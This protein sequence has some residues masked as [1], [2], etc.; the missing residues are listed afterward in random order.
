MPVAPI[1]WYFIWSDRYEIFANILKQGINMYPTI[2]QDKNQY[3]S[4]EDF[5]KHLNKA[6]GH[7]LCGCFLKLNK[8][9]E[10]LTTLPENS[11]FIF[12]DADILIFPNRA[13]EDLINLYIKINADIVFM[14]EALNSS[15]N[16]VGFSLI[17]VCEA[18]RKLFSD[19]IQKSQTDTFGLD[20]SIINDS[21]SNYTGSLFQFPPEFVMTSCT[22]KD[23]QK[24]QSNMKNTYENLMIFQALC[25]P[26]NPPEY[27]IYEKLQ[28]YKTLGVP[29]EFR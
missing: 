23:F 10:L 12:S 14:R 8:T 18:N 15:F 21:L 24:R 9:Y 29:I 5:D 1:P 28:Q 22:F 4:Q 17:K 3:I 7:F 27:V 25:N 19:A 6:K 16:N 2:F 26:E 11:Y 13:L 20:G